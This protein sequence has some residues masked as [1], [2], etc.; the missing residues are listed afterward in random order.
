MNRAPSSPLN[1]TVC[2]YL[3]KCE[4]EGEKPTKALARKFV[5]SKYSRCRKL[6]S[7]PTT[8][9][10]QVNDMVDKYNRKLV[11]PQPG[12]DSSSGDVWLEVINDMFKR[13]EYGISEYGTPLQRGNGRDGLVDLY[14]ELLDATVYI[15][16]LIGEEARTVYVTQ[17]EYDMI[18]HAIGSIESGQPIVEGHLTIIYKLMKGVT[19]KVK[20]G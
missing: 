9:R 7:L 4:V 13:R 8:W 1:L 15:R 6:D 3:A 12:P 2:E 11:E 14:Q 16:S 19:L 5:F 18:G 17:R 20:D 10:Q